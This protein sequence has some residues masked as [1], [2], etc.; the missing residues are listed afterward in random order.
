M[1]TIH[2]YV[3]LPLPEQTLQIRGFMKVLSV[4]EQ[5]EDIVLYC[6]VNN[7]ADAIH[8]LD[9]III[10]TG[11]DALPVKQFDFIGTV[12]TQGGMYMWH[13]FTNLK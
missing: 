11:H 4:D 9:V 13:I 12:K 6:M 1:I 8:M 7:A 10:G 3:L 2:K 5:R